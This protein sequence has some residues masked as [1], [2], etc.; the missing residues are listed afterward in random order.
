MDADGGVVTIND[1]I[2]FI[3]LILP[4]FVEIGP[5]EPCAAPAH[6]LLYF[7][8]SCGVVNYP[9]QLSA[10]GTVYVINSMD[11]YFEV[12]NQFNL[13]EIAIIYPIAVTE[14]DGTVSTFNSN[15]EVCAFIE[16]CF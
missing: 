2:E 5:S 15:A 10:G 1:E 9:N 13:D 11:D 14:S 12:Y 16:D 3:T 7:N 8:Q 4:C 6:V